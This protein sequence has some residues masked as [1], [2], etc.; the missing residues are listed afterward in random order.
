VAALALVRTIRWRFVTLLITVL[1][2]LPTPTASAQGASFCRPSESPHFQFGFQALS[3]ALSDTMG[4]PIECEHPNAT[5]GDTLQRTTTGLAFY[6][7]STNTPTFTNGFD[8]WGLMAGGLAHWMG[9]SIDPPSA[10]TSAPSAGPS[11]S[12]LPQANTFYAQL[13]ASAD[14]MLIRRQDGD[15]IGDGRTETIVTAIGQGC[16]SGSLGLKIAIGP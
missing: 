13:L 15:L 1:L 6:R 10:G 7:K 14:W 2:A 4:S 16:A 5:N 11:P 9:A 8:H 12:D 3:A